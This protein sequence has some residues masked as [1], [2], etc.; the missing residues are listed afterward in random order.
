MQNLCIYAECWRSNLDM[1]FLVDGSG[2]M[3]QEDFDKTLD[4]VK[5]VASN[6]DL[7]HTRVGVM[8]Y[9]YWYGTR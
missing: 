7:Y 3:E 9:S 8:Q 6:F 2:T 4:F 5:N 1:M